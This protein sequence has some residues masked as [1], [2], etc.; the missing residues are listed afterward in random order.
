[1][2]TPV[3]VLLDTA[4]G[5]IYTWHA[6]REAAGKFICDW[7]DGL[8][9]AIKGEGGDPVKL[10]TIMCNSHEPNTV[11]WAIF[12]KNIV[13]MYIPRDNKEK[14]PQERMAD[15]LEKQ[16]NDGDSWRGDE[17]E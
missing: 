10:S 1:M 2:I 4:A 14:T 7:K 3:I 16:M 8:W 9:A 5:H 17:D 6:S 13:G 11:E 12:M 15:V